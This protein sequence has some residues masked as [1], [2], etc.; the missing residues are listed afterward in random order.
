[1]SNAI[2]NPVAGHGLNNHCYLNTYSPT[3]F[4]YTYKTTAG[5]LVYCSGVTT[6]SSTPM[7]AFTN[8]DS[9]LAAGGCWQPTSNSYTSNQLMSNMYPDQTLG[10][11]AGAVGSSIGPAVN[12]ASPVAAGTS[13]YLTDTAGNVVS[14]DSLGNVVLGTAGSPLI[15]QSKPS[16]NTVTLSGSWTTF[17]SPLQS[18]YLSAANGFSLLVL[19][20]LSSF[21]ESFVIL[22]AP[23]STSYYIATASEG[24]YLSWDYTNNVGV[25]ANS[26]STATSWKFNTA[27]NSFS[28]WSS[29]GCYMDSARRTINT[30]SMSSSTL[31]SQ[32]CVSWCLNQGYTV[33]GIEVGTECYCSNTLNGA[34]RA[35]NQS[36]CP[37]GLGAGW[38]LNVYT[39]NPNLNRWVNYGC[40]IDNSNRIL[41]AFAMYANDGNSL[42]TQSNPN[43]SNGWVGNGM[44]IE[45]CQNI[46]AIKGYS[47]AGIEV[48]TE[49]RKNKEFISL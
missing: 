2:W 17:Y 39:A 19:G 3:G 47:Y 4:G 10:C 48:G 15:L 32:Q 14:L 5:S 7:G 41:N 36:D 30:V 24:C 40:W 12:Q 35:P 8:P 9:C 33:A 18:S 34:E 26:L 45:Y 37:S 11:F 20:S 13:F 46:C 44:T 49:C 42:A 6:T 22:Q 27:I 23:G 38:R 28:A 29:L 1:M 16:A 43:F 25:C 21:A 31:T